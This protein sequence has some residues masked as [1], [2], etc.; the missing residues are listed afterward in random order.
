VLRYGYA[1]LHGQFVGSGGVPVP[2]RLLNRYRDFDDALLHVRDF[3]DRIYNCERLHSSLNYLSAAA[4]EALPTL[5]LWRFG[6]EFSKA[7][8]ALSVRWAQEGAANR[9]TRRAQQTSAGNRHPV[10][11]SLAASLV[12]ELPLP[13]GRE[14]RLHPCGLGNQMSCAAFCRVH[15]RFT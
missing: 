2:E 13:M 12:F 7:Y 8:E 6:L 15:L 1:G 9:V 11:A 10:G 3:L 5:T 4:F 14:H